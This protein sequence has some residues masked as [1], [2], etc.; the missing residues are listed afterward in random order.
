M[1][2]AQESVDV[3]VLLA[4]QFLTGRGDDV[5]YS[6]C[7]LTSLRA[8][9]LTLE[10]KEPIHPILRHWAAEGRG[11]AGSLSTADTKIKAVDTLGRTLPRQMHIWAQGH[12]TTIIDHY[13]HVARAAAVRRNEAKTAF[14]LAQFKQGRHPDTAADFWNG[15]QEPVMPPLPPQSSWEKKAGLTLGGWITRHEKAIWAWSIGSSF[16]LIYLLAKWGD[17]LWMRRREAFIQ[18]LARLRGRRPAAK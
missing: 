6:L 18:W 17:R 8:T 11:E 12:D 9:E 16:L 13:F 3:H 5:Q 14:M 1:G 2:S 10:N 15:W 4:G 7:H